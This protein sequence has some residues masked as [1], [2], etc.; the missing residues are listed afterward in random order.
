LETRRSWVIRKRMFFALK[1]GEGSPSVF[2]IFSEYVY[3][4]IVNIFQ[5][6]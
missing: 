4:Y 3:I 5:L 2:Q 1:V 6:K